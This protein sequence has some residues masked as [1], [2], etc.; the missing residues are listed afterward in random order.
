MTTKGVQD[1]KGR[2]TVM[3]MPSLAGQYQLVG[4][5]QHASIR[6][7]LSDTFKA[8]LSL[9]LSPTFSALAAGFLARGGRY[10]T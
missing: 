5:N 10:R 8:N 1:E 7:T 4:I 2:D 3:L 9:P 6:V